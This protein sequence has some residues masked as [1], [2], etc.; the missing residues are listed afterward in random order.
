M[1]GSVLMNCGFIP[2][3]SLTLPP[4]PS[5]IGHQT[6]MV[7]VPWWFLPPPDSPRCPFSRCLSQPL[8]S[9]RSEPVF[10]AWPLRAFLCLSVRFCLY[11]PSCTHAKGKRTSS[12]FRMPG[13]GKRL[14]FS[15]WH[16]VGALHTFVEWSSACKERDR[17]PTTITAIS[18]PL[19][20]D[21]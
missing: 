18:L 4:L 16:V 19:Q 12:G 14:G 17:T 3:A 8:P 2:L 5:P 9:W 13:K 21:P 11:L 15:T 10:P 7:T 20:E 6:V 1:K